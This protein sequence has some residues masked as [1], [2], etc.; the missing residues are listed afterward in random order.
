M[1]EAIVHCARFADLLDSGSVLHLN[2]M[3][4]I[5]VTGGAGFIG[6]NFV[7][8]GLK[9][10]EDRVVSIDK[11]TY[12]A[13][14]DPTGLVDGERY[15][16]VAGDMS[17]RALM[18][19]LLHEHRPTLVINF[20]A[21]THVDRSILFPEEFVQANVVGTFNLLDEVRRYWE[22]LPSPDK[23]LFR[24][25]QIS[26]D[27][28][29]GSLLPH[30]SPADETKAAAPNSPYAATKAA[31]DQLVRAYHRTYGLP[32]AITRCSNNYG[33][34]QHPEKL[35]PLMIHRALREEAL[36]IYGDGMQVRDW[37]Y[38]D[39]HC[40]A[41]HTVINRGRPG[42]VYNISAREERTNLD[43]ALAI[44]A[45]LD[46]EFPRRRGRYADLIEHVADRPGHDRRYA[47]DSSKVC[48]LGWRAQESF[49]SGLKKTVQWYVTNLERVNAV[50][51]GRAY[52]NWATVNYGQRR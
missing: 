30:E 47:L 37:L 12:A 25:L 24:F 3:P 35:I 49:A 23:D 38:V 21:E 1:G 15:W 45:L 28:V 52:R 26:T 11:G 18:R 48:E 20:A 16:P 43:V 46:R 17:D 39:D 36:P 19:R 13:A 50:A 5:I 41:L 22:D 4:N 6:S 40:T 27:E 8:H 44:C 42:E 14:Y 9:Q 31:A 29:Y 7:R 10:S 33:P 2:F 51:N 32:T 34:Y